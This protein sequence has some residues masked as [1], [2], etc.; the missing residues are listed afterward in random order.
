MSY[1]EGEVRKLEA[2]LAQQKVSYESQ[3]AELKK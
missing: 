3:I 2:K 1:F